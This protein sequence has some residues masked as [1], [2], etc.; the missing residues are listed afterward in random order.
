MR[1][2]C[3]INRAK[4]KNPHYLQSN[5]A[6]FRGSVMYEYDDEPH[7]PH[8]SRSDI[9]MWLLVALPL[10]TLPLPDTLNIV[11]GMV[12]LGLCVGDSRMLASQGHNEP[13]ALL[14]LI[15]P[16]YVLARA[17]ALKDGVCWA[18]FAAYIASIALSFVILYIQYS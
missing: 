6:F 11:V 15:S 18:I 4:R 7:A 17:I 14:G 3:P 1:W 16:A 8:K 12:G 2:C 9:L 10:I 5:N 13:H